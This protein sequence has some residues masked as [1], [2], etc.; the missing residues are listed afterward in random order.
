MKQLEK[1]LRISSQDFFSTYHKQQHLLVPA[2][3]PDHFENALELSDIE[4][5]LATAPL[6][7]GQVLLVNQHKR[8]WADQF[9]K[10]DGDRVVGNVVDIQKLLGLLRN[11]TTAI[12]TDM[13]RYIPKL[14]RYCEQLENE[15]GVKLQAN[16]YITP[17]NSQGFHVHVDEHDV[18]V[19][20]LFGKKNWQLYE[21]LVEYPTKSLIQSLKEFSEEE[22]KKAADIEMKPGDLLYVPH[23][24][25]HDACTTNEASVH[26]TLGLLPRRR[27]EMLR[28]LSDSAK[29]NAFFRRPLPETLED[30]MVKE[31]FFEDFKEACHQL[32][33]E[34]DL[35][36]LILKISN[37]FVS[38]QKPD[39]TGSLTNALSL[40]QLTVDSRLKRKTET[41]YWLEDAKWH[42]IVHFYK[43][44]VQVPKPVEHILDVIL[45]EDTFT[46]AEISETLS[47]KVKLDMVKK[48]VTG[49]LV[50]IVQL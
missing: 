38:N 45:G 9:L 44:K 10:L 5:Y 2:A 21:G 33:E 43:E 32:I 25:Y 18:F 30:K 7:H 4:T 24:M 16:V 49:G 1:L 6:Q 47:D 15:L 27:S 8:P 17:P 37:Q 23:G 48:F 34:A 46:P 26:I 14:N 35:E 36:T 11:G 13:A 22:H 19:L 39:L 29:D 28:M 31:A 41:R 20:Q 12:L 42:T 40:E 50:N 3:S